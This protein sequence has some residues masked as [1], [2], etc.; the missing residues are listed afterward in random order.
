LCRAQSRTARID[1]SAVREVRDALQE[2][3]VRDVGTTV[4]QLPE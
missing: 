4:L 2:A 3:L 1:A